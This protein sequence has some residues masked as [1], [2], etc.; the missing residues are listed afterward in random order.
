MDT[1]AITAAL[2]ELSVFGTGI[3]PTVFALSESEATVDVGGKRWKVGYTRKDKAYAFGKPVEAGDT[4]EAF[5]GV[6]E[7]EVIDLTLV[8]D[9]NAAVNWESG[10]WPVVI[11]EAKENEVKQRAYTDAAIANVDPGK[12]VGLP[13]HIDHQGREGDKPTPRSLR[14][15]AGRVTKAWHGVSTAGRQQV[16]GIVHVFDS[17]LKD[18]GR[19]PEFRSL[20]G[21]SHVAEGEGHRERRGGKVWQVVEAITNPV[22]VDFVSKAAFGGRLTESE[23][24]KR[25]EDLTMLETLTE[26]DLRQNRPDLVEVFSK[27]AVEKFKLQENET[28]AVK[29]AQADKAAAETRAAKAEAEL[30]ET[31]IRVSVTEAVANPENKIPEAARTDAVERITGSLKGREIA[32]EKFKETVAEAVK[33]EGS[34]IGKATTKPKPTLEGNRGP[35]SNGGTPEPTELE[36]LTE[37][38]IN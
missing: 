12:Y 3:T 20:L 16:R 25:M 11:I 18:R 26:S 35:V 17:W 23:L 29:Q 8:E 1:K 10:D 14:D 30:R 9:E 31:K 27:A 24:D 36:K 6:R 34:Y 33:A 7:S 37:R 5:S 4:P 21:L 38:L 32:P 15:M 28:D 13:M 19:D 2:I 22:S